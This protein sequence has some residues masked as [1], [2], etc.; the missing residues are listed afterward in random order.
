MKN[1]IPV[2]LLRVLVFLPA[3]FFKELGNFL[4]EIIF[5]NSTFISVYD[6]ASK[7]KKRKK[8]DI[9]YATTSRIRSTLSSSILN[10]SCASLVNRA[11]GMCALYEQTIR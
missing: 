11:H 7:K 4:R 1:T 5:L 8:I 3:Q 9:Y 6:R 10:E 2:F